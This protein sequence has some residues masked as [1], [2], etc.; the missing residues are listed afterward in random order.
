V[1][2]Q[3]VSSFDAVAST[4]YHKATDEV[5]TVDFGHMTDSIRSMLAPVLWLA[6]SKYRP[7]WL[8]GKDP[9]KGGNCGAR[10]GRGGG[11]GTLSWN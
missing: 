8:P 2:A 6:N 5:S 1:V 11:P 4:T 3:T 10:P 9:S 7:T